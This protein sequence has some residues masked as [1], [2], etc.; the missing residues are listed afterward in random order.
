MKKLNPYPWI[1]LCEWRIPA[2]CVL[3]VESFERITRSHVRNVVGAIISEIW[4]DKKVL[5]IED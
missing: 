1:V 4:E 5:I 2:I 3:T